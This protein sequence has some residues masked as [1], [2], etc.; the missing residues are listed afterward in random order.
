MNTKI[1]TALVI[2]VALFGLTGAASATDLW[3][4]VTYVHQET[5]DSVQYQPTN[6]SLVSGAFFAKIV[7]DFDANYGYTTTGPWILDDDV[8]AVGGIGNIMKV[9]PTGVGAYSSDITQSGMAN[10]TIRSLD[11]DDKLPEIEM[12]M[13]KT[14]QVGVTGSLDRVNVTMDSYGLVGEYGALSNGL[15]GCG[16]L[17]QVQAAHANAAVAPNGWPGDPTHGAVKIH[18]VGAQMMTTQGLTAD[19]EGVPYANP[20]VKTYGSATV[21]VSYDAIVDV[22]KDDTNTNWAKINA[23]ADILEHCSVGG[24]LG[25]TIPVVP[26]ITLPDG[27][28]T[29]TF[30]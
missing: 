29:F 14:Q 15:P 8:L 5:L 28:G 18:G 11:A 16:N 12:N 10:I 25:A 19:I 30:P 20:I 7:D 4:Q 27:A 6:E 13:L 2:G 24:G 23:T 17:V 9:E 26:T 21:G 1:I 22:I 3:E